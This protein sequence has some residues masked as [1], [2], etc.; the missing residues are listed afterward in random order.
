MPRTRAYGFLRLLHYFVPQPVEDGSTTLGLFSICGTRPVGA[1]VL[2][3]TT[4]RERVTCE[5]CLAVLAEYGYHVTPAQETL[6]SDDLHPRA[7]LLERLAAQ[8]VTLNDQ[9][10]TITARLGE[11][12]ALYQ[13]RQ[14]A[15]EVR[16]AEHAERL[17]QYEAILAQLLEFLESLK[18]MSEHF[19]D[20]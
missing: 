18:D 10:M 20:H 6:M 3:G 14:L 8:Q 16:T 9:L 7:D 15:Q 11:E 17:R 13:E 19:K 1:L 4:N 5:R 12:H 2:H